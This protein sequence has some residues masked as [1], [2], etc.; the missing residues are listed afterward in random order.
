MRKLSQ[1]NR[2][3]VLC[4]VSTAELMCKFWKNS[5][6]SWKS[7]FFNGCII[8][9]L[10]LFLFI[11]L[12]GKIYVIYKSNK[13]KFSCN[14]FTEY[15]AADAK[16]IITEGGMYLNFEKMNSP[17]SVIVPDRHILSN[18]ATLIRIGKKHFSYSFHLVFYLLLNSRLLYFSGKKNYYTVL[19]E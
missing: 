9:F 1:V 15:L 6:W 3:T 10:E 4:S 18:G 8:S 7:V 17:Q 2:S 5:G 16:R 14:K 19:W 12:F 13:F 11:Y